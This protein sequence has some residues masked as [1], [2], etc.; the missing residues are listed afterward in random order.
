MKSEDKIKKRKT[1]DLRL[2]KYEL[3]H[4]RDLFGVVLPP[5]ASKTLSQALAE[6]EGRPL[7]E[8]K[9]WSKIALLVE[10]AGL[11]AGDD[12]PDFVV[13]PVTTPPISVFQITSDPDGS[14]EAEE[15]E[16]QEEGD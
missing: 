1:Y 10:A 15:E 6:L 12:A 9:L 3:L 8:S 2:T 11:P 13:A 7:V 14:D 16:T 5:E 4:L